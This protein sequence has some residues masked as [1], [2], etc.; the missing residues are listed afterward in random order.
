MPIVLQR[1]T[2]ETASV[3][4][5]NEFSDGRPECNLNPV[6]QSFSTGGPESARDK[7][8][9]DVAACL[10]LVRSGDEGAAR[11]LVEHLRPLVARIIRSHLPQ[12]LN[13]EDLAQMVFVKVFSRLDQFG[14]QAPLEHWVSRIAVNT[15]LNALA[16]ERVR[17]E[18]RLADLSEEQAAVVET[19]AAGDTEVGADQRMAAR[20][21]VEKMLAGLTPPDRLVVTLLH[22]E[23]RTVE[24]IARATGWS[25][26][27]VKVRA[28]RA[29]KKMRKIL[30]RLLADESP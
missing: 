26:P 3:V 6:N 15:C 25:Q 16:H 7:A 13:E 14:G 20:E 30:D 27:V 2:L 17:P 10:S 11:A 19:L 8:A 24:E 4:V 1:F 28:F 23:G 21:L 5:P 18:L 22:L 12:R 29:R 9:L